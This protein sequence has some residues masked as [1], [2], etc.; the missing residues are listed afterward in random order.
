MWA[1][2]ID[3][4]VAIIAAIV[5]QRLL[6][7]LNGFPSIP[8]NEATLSPTSIIAAIALAVASLIGAILGGLAGMR[9]HRRVD[10]VNLERQ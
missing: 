1:I 10:R 8:V 3:T 9:F 6:S 4:V 5:G 2:V 7:R